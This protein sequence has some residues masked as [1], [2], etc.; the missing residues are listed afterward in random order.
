LSWGKRGK[1]KRKERW[2]L[3]EG[4]FPMTSEKKKKKERKKEKILCKKISVSSISNNN[5]NLSPLSI[6]KSVARHDCSLTLLNPLVW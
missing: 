2:K 5:S 1:K 6:P 4:R 3:E